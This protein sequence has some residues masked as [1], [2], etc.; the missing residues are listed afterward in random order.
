MAKITFEKSENKRACH[1]ITFAL[2][3][4]KRE[5]FASRLTGPITPHETHF[6]ANKYKYNTASPAHGGSND[7]NRPELIGAPLVVMPVCG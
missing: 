2:R 6:A 4:A 5:P 7:H 3:P 1:V